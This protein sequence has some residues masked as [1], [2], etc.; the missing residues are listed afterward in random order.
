MAVID[1]MRTGLMFLL[2]L[3]WPAVFAAPLRNIYNYYS[4]TKDTSGTLRI[5]NYAFV[6]ERDLTLISLYYN[7][8]PLVLHRGDTLVLEDF[9]FQPNIIS[10]SGD[11]YDRFE[12]DDSA[13]RNWFR[14]IHSKTTYYAELRIPDFPDK[15]HYKVK[16]RKRSVKLDKQ[17]VPGPAVYVWE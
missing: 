10:F 1:G 7:N 3:S 5:E 14:V 4:V 11:H 9:H 8:A 15:I 6:A 2:L 12:Q 13:E 17:P 16:G